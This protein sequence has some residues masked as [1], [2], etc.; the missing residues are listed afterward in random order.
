L[1]P[2]SVIRF[3]SISSNGLWS[4]E[5]SYAF[6]PPFPLIMA[7]LSPTF[8]TKHL[9][10]IVDLYSNQL[11]QIHN[12]T[13][14]HDNDSTWASFLNCSFFCL[15]LFE[16]LFFSRVKSIDDCLFWIQRKMRIFYHK[17]VKVI[18]KK[19]STCNSSM[20][21]VD[22]KKWAFRPLDICVC[23]FSLRFHYV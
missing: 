20:P 11:S 17:L 22:T 9:V 12:L 15:C 3:C 13:N 21:I 18:S 19:V 23:I 14:N 16:K 10:P 1:P 5:R 6:Y 7:L 4:L 2:A 8:A